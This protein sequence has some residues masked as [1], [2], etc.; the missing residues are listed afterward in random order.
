MKKLGAI[1]AFYLNMLAL[2]NL[3]YGGTTIEELEALSKTRFPEETT[4]D[5]KDDNDQAFSNSNINT[6]DNTDEV[7]VKNPFISKMNKIF[8]VKRAVIENKIKHQLTEE[9]DGEEKLKNDNNISKE[10]LKAT[11]I[12]DPFAEIV[13]RAPKRPWYH[14]KSR[15]LNRD[16]IMTRNRYQKLKSHYKK[17]TTTEKPIISSKIAQEIEEYHRPFIIALPIPPT[18]N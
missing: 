9:Q 15:S 5:H 7:V 2:S 8:K 14:Y 18:F 1:D 11:D 17:T 6:K 3:E 4:D 13:T 16:G 10:N 12:D